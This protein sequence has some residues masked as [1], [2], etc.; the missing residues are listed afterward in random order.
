MIPARVCDI[1]YWLY[2][3]ASRVKVPECPR[4][5]VERWS[6]MGIFD[7]DALLGRIPNR[8]HLVLG[9][10]ERAKLLKRGV[11]PRVERRRR[12]WISVAAEEFE[13]DLLSFRIVDTKSGDII[14]E[15][16]SSRVPA[17]F[18]EKKLLGDAE[19]GDEGASGAGEDAGGEAGEA[20]GDAASG[21]EEMQM[22]AGSE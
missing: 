12:Q 14:Y 13:K 3:S 5:F 22:Q 17:A 4:T 9:I 16:R 21:V 19:S 11:E 10:V 18:D 7:M 20:S 1:D 6:R 15:Y 2:G 8:F